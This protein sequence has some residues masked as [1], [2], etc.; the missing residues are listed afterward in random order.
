ML[1][2]RQIKTTLYFD[3][4]LYKRLKMR[5]IEKNTSVTRILSD[6]A[7]KEVGMKKEK[8]KMTGVE[9]LRYLADHPVKGGPKTP[10]DLSTNDEYL[11]GRLAP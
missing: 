10:R 11:Y 4:E 8:K 7:A 6:C 2:R 1:N 9:F 5:A 3:E